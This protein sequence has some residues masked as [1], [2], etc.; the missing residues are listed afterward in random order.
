M[1]AAGSSATAPSASAA[2]VRVLASPKPSSRTYAG[3]QKLRGIQRHSSHSTEHGNNSDTMELYQIY[4]YNIHNYIKIS[5]YQDIII[6][7]LLLYTYYYIFIYLSIYILYM[8]YYY[9][10]VY[11]YYI[12][13]YVY[14]IY[15]L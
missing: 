8:M 2:A 14:N 13:I 15:T 11:M 10:T 4:I 1:S 7:L 9:I 6:S 5:L 12:H 3:T